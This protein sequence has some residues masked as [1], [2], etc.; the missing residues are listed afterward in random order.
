MSKVAGAKKNLFNEFHTRTNA[1]ER[2]LAP[3]LPLCRRHRRTK[4][5]SALAWF[6]QTLHSIHTR[7]QSVIKT[8][9]SLAVAQCRCNTERQIPSECAR[10][11]ETDLRKVPCSCPEWKQCDNDANFCFL[12]S[13]V[14]DK[15]QRLQC[16]AGYLF[17]RSCFYSWLLQA[18]ADVGDQQRPARIPTQ[19]QDVATSHLYGFSVEFWHYI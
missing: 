15:G 11:E 19:Q 7:T 2:L 18:G 3:S 8:R 16:V 13:G 1:R 17:N 4:S 12:M 10:R 6:N 9:T 5:L 14:Y